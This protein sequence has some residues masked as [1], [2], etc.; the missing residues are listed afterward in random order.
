MKPQIAKAIA[1]YPIRLEALS[2]IIIEK[3]EV[4]DPTLKWILGNIIP[5]A[6]DKLDG[7]SLNLSNTLY[8][9]TS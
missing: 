9:N 1:D 5:Y 4:N 3:L 2:K 6:I 7:I 8:E